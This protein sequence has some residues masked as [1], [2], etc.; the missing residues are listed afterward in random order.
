MATLIAWWLN[1]DSGLELARPRSYARSPRMEA[2]MRALA[3]RL[4]LL[5]EP[6]DVV[7]DGSQR[8]EDLPGFTPLAFCP[9]PSAHAALRALGFEPAPPPA[10]ALLSALTRRSF[11]A[12]LGQTLPGA[13]YV[14]SL[15]A[16]TELLQGG[17]SFTGE[18]LLKRDFSFAARE[19]RRVR[20]TS[21]DASTR[22]FVENSF[23]RGEGLQVEP[24]VQRLADFAR[25]GYVPSHGELLLGPL[26]RQE[27]DARGS[28]VASKLAAP[29]SLEPSEERALERALREAGQALAARGYVGPFG[30]DAFRYLDA[31]GCPAFQPRSEVNVRFSMGYPRAL[32]ERALST[33][34]ARQSDE[35]CD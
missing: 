9:T 13:C 7:L 33:P 23:A 18:W 4:T 19:R 5:V 14:E 10:L 35:G 12:S 1:L 28:W 27:C 31:A 16:L 20:G 26:L 11:G 24:Y 3:P 17:S 32:L 30:V 21:L 6:H 8:A 29:D 34:A 25:H 2:R 22:G 15:A